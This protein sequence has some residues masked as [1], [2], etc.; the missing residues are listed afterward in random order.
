M[1]ND[2][3]VAGYS[4][5]M[6]DVNI[7][8]ETDVVWFNDVGV[9]FV[10]LLNVGFSVVEVESVVLIVVL[11]VVNS[12]YFILFVLF[13]RI[14]FSRCEDITEG[15]ELDSKL[16]LLVFSLPPGETEKFE[17]GLNSLGLVIE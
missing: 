2:L 1:D 16:K 9:D 12:G 14:F 6:G 13:S 17:L 10:E 15:V 4:S 11:Y 7:V 8:V 5:V 3:A